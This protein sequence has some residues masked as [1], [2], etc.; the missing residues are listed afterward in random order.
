MQLGGAEKG[1]GG[2]ERSVQHG[3]AEEGIEHTKG[4][5]NRVR[6][7]WSRECATGW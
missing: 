7:G 2:A 3:N 6:K 5:C 4:G 1:R